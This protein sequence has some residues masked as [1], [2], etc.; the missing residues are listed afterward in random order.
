[1]DLAKNRSLASTKL[2]PS[3]AHLFSRS[4]CPQTWPCFW[5]TRKTTVVW[6]MTAGA[7]AGVGWVAA[8]LGIIALFENRSWTY[9]LA[10]AATTSWPLSRWAPSS[11][12][13]GKLA[14]KRRA[15]FG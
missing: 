6:G 10:M 14:R 4:S 13:G 2:A 3:A 11:A 9:I 8:G 5:P 7:L 15:G 1:M 12:P